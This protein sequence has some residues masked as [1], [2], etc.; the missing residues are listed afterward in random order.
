VVQSR[1][2]TRKISRRGRRSGKEEKIRRKQPLHIRVNI[3]RAIAI[4]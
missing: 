3:P 4:I 2:S 1:K